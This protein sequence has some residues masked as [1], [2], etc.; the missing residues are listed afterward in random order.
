MTKYKVVWEIQKYAIVE[1]KTEL[2]AID[3]VNNGECEE[4]EGEILSGFQV[5]EKPIIKN[6]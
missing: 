1:A 6:D 2:E 5:F 3:K 4:L